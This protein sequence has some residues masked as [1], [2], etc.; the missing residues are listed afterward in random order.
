M[1]VRQ[2]DKVQIRRGN[3]E[4]S[5][6]KNVL[7]LLHTEIHNSPDFTDLNQRA[8]AGD[9]MCCAVKTKLHVCRVPFQ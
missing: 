6:L 2:Q 5:I 4:R 3:R 7:S 9:F 8:A 1:R